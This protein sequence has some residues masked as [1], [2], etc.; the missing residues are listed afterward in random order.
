MIQFGVTP[1]LEFIMILGICVLT[2]AEVF[3]PRD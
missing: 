3:T 1:W 2:V